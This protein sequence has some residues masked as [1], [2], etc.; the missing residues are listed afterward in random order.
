MN[1]S[2]YSLVL[3]C[4]VSIIMVPKNRREKKKKKMKMKMKYNKLQ[5]LNL[6][7]IIK[8]KLEKMDM[9]CLASMVKRLA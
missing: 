7:R 1:N 6:I 5:Y 3:F 2:D 4:E 9:N 8:L